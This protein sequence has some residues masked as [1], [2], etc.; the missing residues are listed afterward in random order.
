V[1]GGWR[2]QILSLPNLVT[3]V[4]L[5]ALPVF[6]WV[7][8]GR[9][10]RATAA[11]ILAFLGATDWV[12]GYLA[13]RL[14]QVTDVGKV[15]DPVADRLLLGTAIIALMIDGAVPT[16]VAVLALVRE[17][18]VG[19]AVLVLYGLGARRVDVSFVGKAGAFSLM[20]AFPLF[21]AGSSDLSWAPQA[22]DLA[23]VFAIPGLVLSYWSAALYVP[24]ARTSL[25][26]GRAA[27]QRTEAIP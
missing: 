12:D 11:F 20:F 2:S 25:A 27:R 1:T 8:L 21:C 26:E 5:A 17:V 7:L 16:W 22:W 6:V 24:M 3:L 10:D 4:R 23:W 9:D 13:R 19:V 18:A 15:L 14:G